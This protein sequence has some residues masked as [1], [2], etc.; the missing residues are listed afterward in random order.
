MS[1]DPAEWDFGSLEQGYDTAPEAKTITVTN[2]GTVAVRLAQPTAVNYEVGTI[3][4]EVINPD[5]SASFTVQ[6]KTGLSANQYNGR[7]SVKDIDGNTL[8]S[9]SVSFAVTEPQPVY[10]LS[11]SPESLEFGTSEE[12]YKNAPG[13]ADCYSNKYR[14]YQHYAEAARE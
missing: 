9:V 6:P 1:V 5:E 8:T 11:I 12:G 13:S 7:I 4:S 3:T 14:K 10:D 2:T